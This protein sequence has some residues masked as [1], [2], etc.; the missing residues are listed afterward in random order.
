M[1]FLLAGIELDIAQVFDL[2]LIL[3]CYLGDIDSSSWM[4][5]LTILVFPGSLGLRLISGSRVLE[6]SLVFVLGSLIVRLPIGVLL[7]LF[8]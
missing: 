3:L 6:L 2:V 1:T 8:G 4:T 7:V 5:S